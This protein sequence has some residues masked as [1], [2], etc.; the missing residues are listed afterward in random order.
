MRNKLFVLLLFV[1]F[2]TGVVLLVKPQ[3]EFSRLEK[4]TLNTR[5]D[6]KIDSVYNGELLSD[7]ENVL[8][9]Q[10]IAREP[11][12]KTY[13]KTKIMLTI[14]DGIE[15]LGPNV[16]QIDDELLINNILLYDE[17]KMNV[18][19]NRGYNINE[20]DLKYPEI[21]TYVYFPTRIEEFMTLPSDKL[22]NVGYLYKDQ[23]M[24]QLNNNISTKSLE[25]NELNE[26]KELFYK[27]DFHW[28]HIG[29]YRGYSDIINMI[30]EDF[31]IDEPREIVEEILY[32][33][34]FD[35]G[36]V[37]SEIGQVS[38]F[39][40]I[41]DYKLDGIKAYELYINGQKSDLNISKQKYALNGNDSMYSD[42]DVYY[43]DNAYERIFKFDQED[44]P[45][46]L[47]FSDSYFNVIQEWF[48]S[49]FNN[50]VIIDMRANEGQFDLDYYINEYDIDIILVSQMYN[51]LYFNGYMF[52]D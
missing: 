26:H 32:P 20:V 50:T 42:Y 9:D 12:M 41:G 7:V 23:F 1:L 10:F 27:T 34:A 16:I 47:V 37:A 35:N 25:I 46:V 22:A 6:I 3:S 14:G 43:G 33:Y 29:A 8:K 38:Y 4:R 49:H 40:T 19:A 24:T 28:N 36:N 44:K 30:R 15:Y 18:A 17:E 51:N 5:D 31:A 48:A 13:F 52:I 11:L 21:K 45:N 2:A 39:D